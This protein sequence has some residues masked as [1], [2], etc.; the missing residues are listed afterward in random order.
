MSAHEQFAEDL[1]LYALGALEGQEKSVLENHLETC[2]SCREEL[3]ALHGD[4]ALLSTSVIG[5]KPPARSRQRLMDAIAKQ[6]RGTSVTRAG[7]RR[8]W[9]WWG[10]LGWLAAAAMLIAVFQLRNENTRLRSSVSSLGALVGQEI[11]ELEN[12]RRVVDTITAPEAQKVVLVA[13][14]TPPQPQGKAFYLRD[15]SSLIFVANNLPPLAPDKIYELWLIPTSGAPIAAGLFKPDAHGSAT[16]VNPPLPAGVEAKT[17]A[18]T[19]ESESGPHDAPRGTGVM[20]G[21][22]L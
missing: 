8:G 19:L 13:G 6:P 17:F 9:G 4:M 16:V 18:V 3:A 2:A 20:Q 1:S 12:A 15:R 5:P 7:D 11:T 14:K 10:A 21:T 22:G